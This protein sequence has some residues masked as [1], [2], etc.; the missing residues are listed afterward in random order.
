MNQLLAG[1]S[2]IRY[3]LDPLSE[4]VIPPSFLLDMS[5]TLPEGVEPILTNITIG[6]GSLFITL[7]T[8]TGDAVAHYAGPVS[9][10][11]VVNMNMSVKGFGWLVV[12]PAC[13]E[14]V[15]VFKN[16][17]ETLDPSVMLRIPVIPNT[18][19]LTV[20]GKKYDMPDKLNINGF[21]LATVYP[22]DNGPVFIRNDDKLSIRT[23]VSEL[24]STSEGE[25]GVTS[26]G[27]A[28]PV[29]GNVNISISPEVQGTATITP[30][31]YEGVVI[32]LLI[33]TE[34]MEPCADD[35]D[36]LNDIIL[37]RTEA[38][39]SIPLPLDYIN[40]PDDIVC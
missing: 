34:G 2:V 8:A 14:E 40:C 27:G 29:N 15:V 11:I 16:I 30:M 39:L 17:A 35:T 37:C 12:G 25:A 7:E 18:F 4:G 28:F 20:D 26:V 3:P 22:G 13:L 21:G 38:G 31:V 24:L 10:G 33:T 5:L 6:G 1:N 36:R 19:T 23:R 9:P 32:G